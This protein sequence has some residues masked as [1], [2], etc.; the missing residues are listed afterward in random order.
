MKD[1]PVKTL[2]H[3]SFTYSFNKCLLSFYGHKHIMVNKIPHLRELSRDE[4]QPKWNYYTN[5]YKSPNHSQYL[6]GKV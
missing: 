6:E 5:E 2:R 3:H 1:P 4:D